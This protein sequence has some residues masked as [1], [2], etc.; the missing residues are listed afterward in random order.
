MDYVTRVF[1]DPRDIPAQM[2]DGLCEQQDAPTPF[3]LH[4]Y[5]AALHESG[6]ASPKTVSQ[7]IGR[8]KDDMEGEADHDT[9]HDEFDSDY[10]SIMDAINMWEAGA[11]HARKL[12]KEQ[13]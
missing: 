4:A 1:Q 8:L 7:F 11:A 2:W 10:Y 9:L 3:M 5:L 13:K 12:M 6:S